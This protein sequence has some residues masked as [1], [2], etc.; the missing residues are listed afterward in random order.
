MYLGEVGLLIGLILRLYRGA[1]DVLSLEERR[2]KHSDKW[3]YPTTY[4][5]HGGI[6]LTAPL[7]RRRRRHAAA[8]EHTIFLVLSALLKPNILIKKTPQQLGMSDQPLPAY[9][10]PDFF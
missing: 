4:C 1:E 5:G 3:D 8:E 9:F 10:D 2:R 7:C 6:Y